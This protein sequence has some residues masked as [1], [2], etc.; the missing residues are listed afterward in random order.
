MTWSGDRP[1]SLSRRDRRAELLVRIGASLGVLVVGLLV[2]SVAI[3]SVDA[4][5]R[6]RPLRFLTD[7][8]WYPLSDRFG[9]APMAVASAAVGVGAVLL[10]APLAL[11]TA[12]WCRAYAAG[13][14][15]SAL[16]RLLEVMAGMPSVVLGLWGLTVVVPRVA[17]V[18]PP[19]ACLATASLVLAVMLLPTLAL[20]YD[21][22]L[23]TLPVEC[24]EAAA[25]LGLGRR[26]T[27]LEV[28]VPAVRPA[29]VSA[30]LLQLARALGETMVVL[31]V[32]GNVVQVPGGPFDPVRTLSANM[33]LEMAYAQGEHRSALFVSGGLLLATGGLLL[34]LARGRFGG[35]RHE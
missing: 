5:R 11:G 22:A 13:P 15:A 31:M 18:Q 2:A 10:A 23:A 33:A 14:L 26:A 7:E 24:H 35:V 34:R 1:S 16:R 21:E 8:S 29:L 12:F 19:G 27:L 28:M 9:M 32:A 3:E 4:L 25:A 20:A 17:A 6:V 30:T